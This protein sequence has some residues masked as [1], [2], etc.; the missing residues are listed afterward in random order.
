MNRA[1]ERGGR[2]SSP[3]Q[4]AL[5]V[6]LRIVVMA[7]KIRASQAEDS[8]HLGGSDVHSQQFPG[9][10]QIDDTPVHLGKALR[11]VPTVHPTSIDLCGGVSR[12]GGRMAGVQ[13][14]IDPIRQVSG[15]LPGYDLRGRVQQILGSAGQDGLRLQ[16]SD[17]GSRTGDG[18]TLGL[19][20]AEARQS[21]QVTPVG[22]G[23]VAAIGVGQLPA[24]GGRQLRLQAN[25]ADANPSLQMAGTSLEHHARLMTIG[26]HGF[27]N[28][29][30]GLIEIEENIAGIARPAVGEEV[31]VKTL[32]VAC[33]QKTHH[34]STHQ[35]SGSPQPFSWSWPACAAVNHTDE[36]ELIRHP[37][38]L[39]ADSV[40]GKKESAV[41]HGTEN[42]PGSLRLEISFQRMVSRVLTSCLSSGDNPA[43]NL[44]PPFRV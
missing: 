28:T 8:F 21:S 14:R 31:Q 32:T 20:I 44:L 42:E 5:Q 40:Q 26:P 3:C 34:C 39:A 43:T 15:R 2:K 18:A 19:V 7:G 13:A 27:E 6:V 17:P 41:E 38:Q 25:G 33:A 11:N 22:A 23:Q 24:Q 12:Y 10:P 1:L 4:S 9:E 36:V 30:A 16:D 35:L 29:R 37:R